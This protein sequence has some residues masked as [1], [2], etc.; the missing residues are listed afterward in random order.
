MAAVQRI[1]SVQ[2]WL[3]CIA[4]CFINDGRELG[5]SSFV[6]ALFS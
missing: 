4:T 1:E 6:P 3:D 2:A 5:S